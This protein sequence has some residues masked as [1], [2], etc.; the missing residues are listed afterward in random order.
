MRGADL[1]SI[2]DADPVA[3]RLEEDNNEYLVSYSFDTGA[4]VA[5]DPRTTTKCSVFINRLPERMIH[6][7]GKITHYPPQKPSTALARVSP[8]LAGSRL[9]YKVDLPSPDAAIDL[10]AWFRWA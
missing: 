10:L 9:L 4:Q 6:R 3:V 8:Q 1:R 2:L 5:F 7:L